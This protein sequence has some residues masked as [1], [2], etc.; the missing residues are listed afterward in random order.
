[1]TIAEVDASWMKKAACV[2][3]DPSLFYFERDDALSYTNA[4][5]ARDVCR[6]CPVR[7][8]CFL[9]ACDNKEEFGV[10]GGTMPDERRPARFK[11]T[12]EMIKNEIEYLQI[13]E[14]NPVARRAALRK[15]R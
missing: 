5:Q 1:M 13:M 12:L 4:K 15:R 8:E 3:L 11:Q 9:V 7:L 2:G 14:L 10:W 6:M